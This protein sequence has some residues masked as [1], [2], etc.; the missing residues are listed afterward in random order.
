MEVVGRP[1][2]FLGA[3]DD[4][5]YNVYRECPNVT[6]KFKGDVDMSIDLHIHSKDFQNPG[7]DIVIESE[8]GSSKIVENFIAN[9]GSESFMLMVYKPMVVETSQYR[10]SEHNTSKKSKVTLCQLCVMNELFNSQIIG[11]KKD[12]KNI[13]EKIND[14]PGE[15]VKILAHGRIYYRNKQNDALESYEV[16]LNEVYEDIQNEM[17]TKISSNDYNN[18]IHLIVK[19][20]LMN[21]VCNITIGNASFENIKSVKGKFKWNSPGIR[22]RDVTPVNTESTNNDLISNF[23][24]C[25]DIC[26]LLFINKYFFDEIGINETSELE[27]WH[28]R[29]DAP[30]PIKLI[31]V[32]SVKFILNV[33]SI[34]D[35]SSLITLA[36]EEYNRIYPANESMNFENL[37]RSF[38]QIDWNG[39]WDHLINP[40]N[41]KNL[42]TISIRA[43]LEGKPIKKKDV[44]FE[45]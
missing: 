31:I 2:V 3:V 10:D 28:I 21:L 1:G 30:M 22:I 45:K 11:K 37:I 35:L 32:F 41:L 26:C 16:T 23:L 17:K 5:N 18:L 44:A 9:N 40:Q 36:R 24:R 12:I 15:F 34:K 43:H 29:K 25:V 42:Y 19:L 6:C 13:K 39:V 20:L 7:S 8:K 14:L 4:V 27:M 38:R 33:Q